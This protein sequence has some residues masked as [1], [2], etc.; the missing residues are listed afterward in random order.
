MDKQDWSSQFNGLFSSPLG[1]E[2]IRT[3]TEDLH[4]NIV[5]DAQKSV[6][7]QEKAF[8]LLNQAGGVIKAIEHL[9]FLSVVPKDEGSE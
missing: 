1:E 4:D 2:L 7:S 6:G 3:L 9:Q 5:R 8:G